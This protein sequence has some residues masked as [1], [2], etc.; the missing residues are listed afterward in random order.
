MRPEKKKA[1]GRGGPEKTEC[2]QERNFLF[3][4]PAK[5]R[6]PVPSRRSDA[7]SGTLAVARN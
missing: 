4:K 5:P 3:S 7:G 6:N 1:A 2:I